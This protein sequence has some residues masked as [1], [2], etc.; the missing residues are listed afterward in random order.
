MKPF[1]FFLSQIKLLRFLLK[2]KS[3]NLLNSSIWNIFSNYFQ[4]TS[5]DLICL[6][7]SMISK[8]KKQIYVN[9][10]PYTPFSAKGKHRYCF[11]RSPLM[12][13]NLLWILIVLWGHAIL[14]VLNH[15][16]YIV[17]FLSD[18]CNIYDKFIC[19]G[20]DFATVPST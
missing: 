15:R 8:L 5:I 3:I 19:F 2:L 13:S 1:H 7:L 12:K 14:L 20:F 11:S 4:L 16:V 6:T 10:S 9:N 17:G 18:D